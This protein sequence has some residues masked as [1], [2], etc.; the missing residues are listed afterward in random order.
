MG[1]E[2]ISVMIDVETLGTTGGY[3]VL[4]IG[5]LPFKEDGNDTFESLLNVGSKYNL[6]IN[7][8]VRLGYKIDPNTMKWWMKQDGNARRIVFSPTS[9][10]KMKPVLVKLFSDLEEVVNVFS[11]GY[12]D[13][14]MLNYMSQREL[15]KELIL[16]RKHSD[17]RTLIKHMEFEWDSSPEGFIKHDPL[18]DCIVQAL[19]IQKLMRG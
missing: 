12:M 7:E 10:S 5:Y 18:H 4:S 14:A 19:A 16:Y 3:V 15:G 1:R 11:Y 6:D 8:Q 9:V 13:M 2:N 17:L